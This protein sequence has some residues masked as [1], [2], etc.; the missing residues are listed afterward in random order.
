[1]TTETFTDQTLSL[2]VSDDGPELAV[3]W[4]GRSTAREPGKFLRPIL[5]GQLEKA[6][7]LGRPLLLDFCAVEFFN[8]STITPVIRLL[9][10]A[11]QRGARLTVRYRK[12]LRWQDLSFSALK[13][14][15]GADERIRIEGA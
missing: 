11:R 9:E 3:T 13:G 15:V 5:A 4:R 8:S 14:F 10:E 2:E 6:C 7:A 12:D 1:M